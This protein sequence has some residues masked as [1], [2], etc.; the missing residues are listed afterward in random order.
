MFGYVKPCRPELRVKEDQ[1]YQAA[2]CGLCR[3]MGKCTGCLSRLFLS[4]D[5]VFLLL[6]RIAL[7]GTAAELKPRRCLVHPFRP[8]LMME[9][10]ASAEYCAAV[11]VLLSYEKAEDDVC[12][13]RGAR[14][15]AAK[16]IRRILASALRRAEC[17]AALRQQVK[18]ALS[19][20]SLL[21]VSRSDSIDDCAD[22]FGDALAALFAY[23]L[24]ATEARIGGEIGR[25]VG[26][27]LYVL[28]AMD[29]YEK[30]KRSGNYNTLLCAYGDAMTPSAWEA[31]E[32]GI[33]MD[34]R[35]ALAALEL[36]DFSR[37]QDVGEI[38]RNVL[39]RGIPEEAKAI[40]AKKIPKESQ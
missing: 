9:P 4:Y 11:S 22:T 35:Q 8:R 5:I 25:R 17:P 34:L 38:L 12:D 20:L 21:E 13:S 33:A 18:D 36:M 19:R 14:R 15:F 37:C 6:T 31:M 32:M 2:Y 23:G 29:D 28:D 24:E 27:V 10:N 26:R 1:L 30:D 39:T 40:A 7:E 16:R 3:T